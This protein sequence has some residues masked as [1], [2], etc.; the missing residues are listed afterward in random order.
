MVNALFTLLPL[1]CIIAVTQSLCLLPL[2]QSA[3][4]TR[5][6]TSQSLFS[7]FKHHPKVTHL[8]IPPRTAPPLSLT[9][10]IFLAASS[11]IRNWAPALSL[12]QVPPSFSSPA[13][14][15]SARTLSSPQDGIPLYATGRSPTASSRPLSQRSLDGSLSIPLLPYP[16]SRPLQ[17]VPV[18]C[19]LWRPLQRVIVSCLAPSPLPPRSEHSPRSRN[20]PTRLRLR[21]QHPH[22]CLSFPLGAALA[23]S[24]QRVPLA[25]TLHIPPLNV[26]RR[27][28]LAT[29]WDIIPRR[30]LGRHFLRLPL[31]GLTPLHPCRLLLPPHLYF[32]LLPLALLMQFHVCLRCRPLSRLFWVSLLLHPPP[33]F[34][35]RPVPRVSPSCTFAHHFL[36]HLPYA[37]RTTILLCRP[38]SWTLQPPSSTS[39]PG[40]SH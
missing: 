24:L 17:R 25:L 28:S 35:W 3:F 32:P 15:T 12:D 9:A 11:S 7:R 22:R 14:E 4:L 36:P 19:S 18:S 23:Y 29:F 6:L 5:F 33:S 1:S 40:V 31:D 2:L 16:L 26:F 30:F 10:L 21:P 38:L 34:T 13:P 39:I 37:P 20:I 27:R 8:Q